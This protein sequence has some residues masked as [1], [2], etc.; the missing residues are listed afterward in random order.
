[1]EAQSFVA[2]GQNI[3][4]L[5]AGA[6]LFDVLVNRWPEKSLVGQC[7]SGLAVGCLGIVVMT[8]PWSPV[9]GVIIDART[10]LLGICGLFMGVV[11]TAVASVLFI[12]FRLVEGGAGTW[13]GIALIVMSGVVGV[14]WRHL[15]HG[16]PAEASW[17]EFLSFGLILHILFVLLALTLPWRIVPIVLSRTWLP[18]LLLLPV[19][20]ALMG[21]FLAGRVNRAA[22]E[23][24]IREREEIFS[25]TFSDQRA[26]QLLIDPATG[27]I[28]EANKAA[29]HFYGWTLD[30]FRQ[31]RISQIN[32]LSEEEVAQLLE[33]VRREQQF[34]FEFKHY[35]ADGTTRHVEVFSSRITV[36][37]VDI[38]HS[39]IHDVTDKTLAESALH[40]SENRL[41]LAVEAA[42]LGL[43]DWNLMNG[44]MVIDERWARM[45]GYSLGELEPMSIG[46]WRQM[47]HKEDLAKAELLLEKHCSGFSESYECELRMRHKDGHV[48]W[49]ADRG[50]IY[51]WDG[52]G[53]PVRMLGTH[54]NITERRLQQDAIN[55][56][57]RR[58]EILMESSNDGILIIDEEHRIVEAN[59]RFAEM[60]GYSEEELVGMHTWD[61]VAEFDEEAIREGFG[62]FSR[63]DMV[64]ESRH[65]RKNGST[66]DVEVS[67]T[68]VDVMDENLVLAIVRDISERKRVQVE[69]RRQKEKAEGAS[70][71]KSEFLANMSHEIRTPMNG[72]LGMLQLLQTTS[73]D[74]EQSDYIHTAIQSSKRLSRLLSDI[75]DLSRVEAGKLSLQSA[76]FDL[77]ECLHQVGELF[78]FTGREKGVALKISADPD[79]SHRIIGD[80]T[81]LQQV[82]INLVGNAFKFTT[83]GAIT[84]EASSLPSADARIQRVLFV[85]TD[86]GEGIPEDKLSD[87]FSPFTQVHQGYTREYQGAGLGLSICKR[88]IDLMG[89]TMS[90]DTVPGEG[91]TVYFSLSFQKDA[92]IEEADSRTEDQPILHRNLVI[93]LAEDDR[94]NHI[95]TKRLLEKMGHEVSGVNNGVEALD[96]LRAGE[97]DL[98]LM[99]I[100][101]PVMNGVDAIKAIRDGR[102]GERHTAIPII[103]LTAYAM[104][105]DEAR[106][107]RAGTDGY[108]AKPVSA[109]DLKAALD[110]LF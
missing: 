62:D 94:V 103:A 102:A 15:R 87:L 84:V 11:P 76:S 47:C 110:K 1:M 93:L 105:E 61:Y 89:G 31:M 4:L 9:P 101:M 17:A 99:D 96:A 51:E 107:S 78:E 52:Q 12:G 32:R 41:Q 26:I 90:F 21:K 3:S 59:R 28:L 14:S 69:L 108:L 22:M 104:A 43:W 5:L 88:L 98:V 56:E 2:L 42:G 109:A 85:V 24:Q 18:V 13:S 25:K 45:L 48:V 65:R 86:T 23:E 35:L 33:S 58:Y 54:R 72:I 36:R 29:E 83:D 73:L 50:K 6:L 19:S 79:I 91:T 38:L 30:E 68:G 44:D 39:I 10:V 16:P 66:V 80:Q 97:F 75:L 82:L 27:L 53:N 71:A 8:A 64:I 37:G 74:M 40:E 67:L 77:E 63:V 57:I 92:L 60:L 7:V 49:I 46:T 34:R 20:T 100:Q 55:R 95:A 106:I 81:R 70:K